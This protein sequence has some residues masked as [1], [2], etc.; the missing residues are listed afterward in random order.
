MARPRGTTPPRS[1]RARA[2]MKPALVMMPARWSAGSVVWAKFVP[3]APAG[4]GT[5]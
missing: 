2:V 3:V 5:L 4:A 1:D